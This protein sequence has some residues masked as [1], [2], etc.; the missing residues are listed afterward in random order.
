[1]KVTVP[2]VS[3]HNRDPVL[4]VDLQ[5]NSRDDI[6]R[7][8]TGGTDTHVIV[9]DTF[10]MTLYARSVTQVT[11]WCVIVCDTCV[12]CADMFSSFT[13]LVIIVKY[14]GWSV[15]TPAI[16]I[17]WILYRTFLSFLIVF[18]LSVQRWIVTPLKHTAAN[19]FL[20]MSNFYSRN[21]PVGN[22]N[23]TVTISS[24]SALNL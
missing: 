8:A 5:H 3:F 24:H 17:T 19:E 22:N 18:L 16:R 14:A 13:A 23:C 15:P 4:S 20:S 11:F 9:S 1:M 12:I 10:V 2:E 7:M 6:T 21:Q